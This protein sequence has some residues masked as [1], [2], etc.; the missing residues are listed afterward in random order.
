[1]SLPVLKNG[2][3]PPGSIPRPRLTPLGAEGRVVQNRGP[4]F[5]TGSAMSRP[6]HADDGTRSNIALKFAAARLNDLPYEAYSVSGR[7]L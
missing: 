3:C 6:C 1:M 2:A 5:R 4:P 7:C